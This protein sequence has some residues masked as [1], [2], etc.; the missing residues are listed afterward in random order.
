MAA[1]ILAL[2]L[3]FASGDDFPSLVVATTLAYPVGEFGRSAL[4][5][6]TQAPH[7]QALM[8]APFVAVGF[9]RLA[10][11]HAHIA[12]TLMHVCFNPR[13]T[14]AAGRTST[15]MTSAANGVG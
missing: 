6:C 14:S 3:R 11:W 2:P 12:S 1:R 13:P 15:L 8:C 10:L 7:V 4:G 5:A 9:R